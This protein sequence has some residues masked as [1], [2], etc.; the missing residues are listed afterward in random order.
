VTPDIN[1]LLFTVGVSLLTGLVFGLAPAWTVFRSV[2]ASS[3]RDGGGVTDPKLSRTFGKTLVVMQVTLSVVLMSSAALFVG[4]L[5]RLRGQENGFRRD[6]VLIVRLDPSRSGYTPERLSRAYEDLLDRLGQSRFVRS[7]SIAAPTPAEGGGAARFVAVPGFNERPEDRRYVSLA[8]VAPRYFDT[9]G[10]RLIDG[11]DFRREDRSGPRVAI[12]NQAMKQYYFRDREAVG[13]FLSFDNDRSPYEIVGVASDAKYANIR[14]APPRTVY[15]NTFQA[16]QPASDF[17]LHTGV[18]AYAAAPEARQA[19]HEVLRTV[20]VSRI[21]SLSDQVDAALIAERITASL[22]GVFGGVGCLLA[23]LGIYGLLAYTT[24]RR[25]HEIGVRMAL[26]ATRA[27]VARMVILEAL[28]LTI[29]GLIF[30]GAI[31]FWSKRY[32]TAL[33]PDLPA[34]QAT[35]ILF[36]ICVTI[37]VALIAVALPAYRASRVEPMTALRCE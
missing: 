7:A 14:E 28:S 9:L 12:I 35:P 24:A 20:P 11:R 26:G 18:D 2:S 13:Q 17:I 30:G 1:V 22:S 6:N 21:T 34:V 23:G 10:I 37:A 25:I 8:W 33:I 3:L 5:L 15:L 16:R 32:I 36:G 19:I 31:A 29:L 4:H 27:T